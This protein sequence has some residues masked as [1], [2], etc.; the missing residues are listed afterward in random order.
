VDF[1]LRREEFEGRSCELVQALLHEVSGVRHYVQRFPRHSESPYGGI[2]SAS[3]VVSGQVGQDPVLGPWNQEEVESTSIDDLLTALTNEK[4]VEI[5]EV[6][7]F[8][9][10]DIEG[11]S[12]QALRGFPFQR[13]CVR[14][15][16]IEL[17][18]PVEY[19]DA[20]DI[21]AK[22][23]YTLVVALTQDF[24]FVHRDDCGVGRQNR[25][26]THLP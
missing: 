10:L 9:T 6:I 3:E 19:E 15:W 14:F 20:A 23:N 22:N 1:N 11:V 13:H 21:L 17:T 24:M 5:P 25:S 4:H 12:V 7:D 8:V 26:T 16:A 2:L 18:T